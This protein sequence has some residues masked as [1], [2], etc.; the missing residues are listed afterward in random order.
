MDAA[1]ILAYYRRRG[2]RLK[3]RGLPPARKSL[4]LLGSGKNTLLTTGWQQDRI[5]IGDSNM[6]DDCT[7]A[8]SECRAK[9]PSECPYHG[10]GKDA[11]ANRNKGHEHEPFNYIDLAPDRATFPAKWKPNNFVSAETLEDHVDRHGERMGAK[12]TADYLDKAKAFLTSPRG[13]YGDAFVGKNGAIGRYDYESHIFAKANSK[14]VVIT[15]WNLTETKTPE[16]ADKY[17]EEEKAGH[18]NEGV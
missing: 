2:A 4:Q 5:I 15:C 9:N 6:D 3:D 11:A 16:N 10:I 8:D 17:W 7:S 12:T 18:I 14:G 13:K 1:P